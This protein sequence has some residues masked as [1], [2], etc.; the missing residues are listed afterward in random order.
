MDYYEIALNFNPSDHAGDKRKLSQQC[1]LAGSTVVL[2]SLLS[3]ILEDVSSPMEY[4]CFHSLQ[5]ESLGTGL[6]NI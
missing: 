1:V 6:G 4:V 2:L 5:P 3:T